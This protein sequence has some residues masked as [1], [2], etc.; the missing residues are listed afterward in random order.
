MNR[1]DP[2]DV[3]RYKNATYKIMVGNMKD[4][5]FLE[6]IS[7][8]NIKDNKKRYRQE[9]VVEIPVERETEVNIMILM[10]ADE[11]SDEYHQIGE[12]MFPTLYLGVFDILR[13]TWTLIIEEGRRWIQFGF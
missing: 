9:N 6:Q 10:M 7:S 1:I 4:G 12:R 2:E 8:N 11:N 13:V 5:I 3:K